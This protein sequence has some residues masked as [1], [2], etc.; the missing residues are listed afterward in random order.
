MG[1]RKHNFGSIKAIYR[2][3][4]RYGLV[5][6]NQHNVVV[7]IDTIPI[8]T[9]I[10]SIK[11]LFKESLEQV[12]AG[13]FPGAAHYRFHDTIIYSRG[14]K[15]FS[16]KFL[17]NP[18]GLGCPFIFQA[19]K[20]KA[21]VIL[22]MTNRLKMIKKLLTLAMLF[23]LVFSTPMLA[24]DQNAT[25]GNDTGDTT[26]PPAPVCE[27]RHDTESGC[28]IEYCDGQEVNKFCQ[29]ETTPPEPGDGTSGKICESFYDSNRRCTITKCTDGF[30]E[31]KC[32]SVSQTPVGG[33]G[34]GG[35]YSEPFTDQAGNQCK[36][37]I[38]TNADGSTY[39][40]GEHCD[41][42]DQRMPEPRQGPDNGFNDQQFSQDVLRNIEDFEFYDIEQRQ[43]ELEDLQAEG[44]ECE[45]ARQLI[46]EMKKQAA[47][48][49][50]IASTAPQKAQDLL[51]N[52]RRSS[53]R[54]IGDAFR[55]C[56]E[57]RGAQQAREEFDRRVEDMSFFLEDAGFQL[58]DLEFQ[59]AD[60]TEARD[61]LSKLKQAIANGKNKIGAADDGREAQRVL[62]ELE[63]LGR[64]FQRAMEKL[65]RSQDR[66]G[67]GGPG[68][69]PGMGPE[70]QDIEDIISEIE[71]HIGE[72]RFE[73][74]D[75]ESRGVDVTEG[76]T[77]IREA[78]DLLAKIKALQDEGKDNEAFKILRNFERFGQKAEK[79]FRELHRQAGFD[80][81]FEGPR[82]ED[83]SVAEILRE[84][85]IF[86]ADTEEDI[87][88]LA[89]R[90]VDVT[91]ARQL[92]SEIKA[93]M[94]RVKT[95]YGTGDEAA[96]KR[97]LAEAFEKGDRLDKLLSRG[98]DRG[99]TDEDAASEVRR[100]IKDVEG[101]LPGAERKLTQLE[102]QGVN[103]QSARSQ[104]QRI[105]D[106]IQK[107]R[108]QTEQGN[109]KAA[110]GIL[111]E[112]MP[113]GERIKDFIRRQGSGGA[114]GGTTQD[115]DEALAL[116][117]VKLP[118]VEQG[119]NEF[120]T[121]GIDTSRAESLLTQVRALV[122]EATDSHN[123]GR[124]DE[125]LQI[126]RTAF[127]LG[128]KLER[129]FEDYKDQLFS[130]NPEALQE[131]VTRVLGEADQLIPQ[132]E[133]KLTELRNAGKDTTQADALLTSIKTLVNTAR[134]RAGSGQYRD[135]MDTLEAAFI[136]G[137]DLKTIGAQLLAA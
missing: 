36:R 59:G 13:L 32:D 8:E 131:R 133:A 74:D 96:A 5:S 114:D 129:V 117:S 6:A 88:R 43:W 71:F 51:E 127:V 44:I 123:Q 67:P 54:N 53:G 25:G 77:L 50:S 101:N 37:E 68:G 135:A 57:M 116:A 45:Q 130:I 75:L 78:E 18:R 111:K 27:T 20:G 66:R 58:D 49:K 3:C 63:R 42:Q 48:A 122:Q 86:I 62:R 30:N 52:A 95:A 9:Q 12:H 97:I 81:D 10:S 69:G 84:A 90:G 39:N 125:A 124:D 70:P 16:K 47:E 83:M 115:V 104:I 72:A 46:D 7:F 17:K 65:W 56:H 91:E 4:V 2:V 34:G 21:E 98:R 23:T 79:V 61:L 109:Y 28:D 94:E 137:A 136:L 106:A 22:L 108:D 134:Q 100:I 126:L 31:E 15:H 110:L 40:A 38:C 105:R 24:Q 87:D 64:E 93:I 26:T 89:E 112:V 120:K 29:G 35:C 107:A 33:S 121:R 80:D 19:P 103:T 113:L 99:Y 118:D 11:P 85:P 14:F 119:L 1:A 128:E 55:A 60:T 82:P 102:G 132:V 73:L 76:R 41:F 92:L